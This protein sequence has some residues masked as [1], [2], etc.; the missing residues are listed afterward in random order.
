MK[1][2]AEYGTGDDES[3]YNNI[4]SGS[5]I[6]KRLPPDKGAF[7]NDYRVIHQQ[8]NQKTE[9]FKALGV[10]DLGFEPPCDIIGR[11][12]ISAIQRAKTQACKQLLANISCLI[13]SKPPYPQ[14]LIHQCTFNGNLQI[15]QLILDNFKNIYHIYWFIDISDTKELGCY[16][17]NRETKLL[18]GYK[19]TLVFTNS[20]SACKDICL[21]SGFVY[22]GVEYG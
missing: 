6:Q 13:N 16:R 11:E 19:T 18:P 7:S 12:P 15:F 21:Q 10:D 8:S 20:H 3:N 14:R 9:Q 2:I 17:D 1:N 5:R 4:P 22:A